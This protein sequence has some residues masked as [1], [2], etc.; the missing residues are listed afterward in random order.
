MKVQISNIKF[1]MTNKLQISMTKI[2]NLQTSSSVPGSY[3]LFVIWCLL[4]VCYLEFGIWNFHKT[5]NVIF[6]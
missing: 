5:C 6:V 3:L 4:F 1:Q 2:P